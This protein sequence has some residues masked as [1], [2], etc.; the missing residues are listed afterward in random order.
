M[1]ELVPA[2]NKD[3]KPCKCEVDYSIDV[4]KI[5]TPSKRAK[6]LGWYIDDVLLADQ[7]M[8]VFDNYPLN[9]KGEDCMFA[10][11]CRFASDPRFLNTPCIVEKVQAFQL[12]LAYVRELE[13]SPAGITDITMIGSLIKL[14]LNT[15]RLE[16]QLGEENMTEVITSYHGDSKTVERRL[17]I[18]LEELRFTRAEIAKIF[19]KLL[20]SRESRMKK[21]IAEGNNA[22]DL[23]SMLQK[24][25]KSKGITKGESSSRKRKTHED[26]ED[27]EFTEA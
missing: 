11:T 27:A 21:A 19:D 14:N 26:I 20:V 24:V 25:M 7:F 18:L 16:L 2:P 17:N 15:R 22:K 9:C 8:G 1:E 13:V 3:L 5:L 10:R 4:D 23:L 12:F 6:I